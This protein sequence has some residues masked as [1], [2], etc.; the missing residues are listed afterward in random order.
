MAASV[1]IVRDRYGVPHIY[2]PTDASVVFGHA[3]AQAEDHFE[4]LEYNVLYALGRSAEIRGEQDYWDNLLA[5]AFEIPRLASEEYAR[6]AAP[7]RAIYDAYAAGVNH[8][9]ASN[10]EVK[11]KLITRFEPWHTLAMLR[12]RYWLAE[13]IWDTGLEREE[14]RIGDQTFAGGTKPAGKDETPDPPAEPA[15]G[16]NMWAVAPARTAEGH[17]LLFINPHVGFFGPYQYY[18][19]HLHSEEGLRF[20]G[21]GR[22]GFP[23][24]Y[25]GHNERLGWSH[26]DNY[27]DRGDLYAEVFDDPSDPLSYRY[28]NTRRRATEWKETVPVL[29]EGRTESRR[30]VFRKTH[31]GPL[32]GQRNGKLLAVKL[33]KAAEGGWYDQWHAMARAQSLPEFRRAL[34]RNAIPYM[35]V[36]YADGDGNILY[37]YNGIV[38]RR[39][40]KVDW[41]APVDGSDPG[42]EW[43]GYHAT[44][45]LPQVLNPPSGYLQNTNSTPFTVTTDVPLRPGSFPDYMIGPEDD[46][47]RARRSRR[48]LA[49]PEKWTFDDW[50][51]AATDTRVQVA[52]EVLPKLATAFEELRIR[53]TARAARLEPHVRLLLGWNR[54][55]TVESPAMTLFHSMMIRAGEKAGRNLRDPKDVTGAALLEALGPT[56]AAL[57]QNWKSNRV[58]WGEV[59]RLQRR[60]WNAGQEFR[61]DVPSLPVPG[62]PGW[63]GMIYVFNAWP[64]GESRRQ[65]GTSGN[66]YVSVVE[67]AP[68]VRAASVVYF[69][70]SGRPDSPHYFDQAPIYARGQ[71]K[72]AWF[73]REE[74]SANAVRRYQPGDRAVG[75]PHPE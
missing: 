31:H 37:V 5:R 47:P 51:R 12:A 50:S 30:A 17:A 64:E 42:T 3:Y 75:L 27:F 20:S 41:T 2:G 35:N 22:V 32:V 25:V 68:R 16:S 1:T 19:A 34:E 9:L 74:V 33:A 38:P 57:E 44:S 70:Q 43:K 61:D 36:I 54:V 55:S 21:V 15:Q 24:P 73:H 23:F 26:T 69:G 72:P 67:F 48:I 63:L 46:N 52:D 8:Y 53:D 58:P 28:G 71:F 4:Q 60:D 29:V 7:L 49:Q 18:E 56:V 62:G 65:Y 40:R 39:D 14:I 10:P 66:S 45:E 6:A 11:P 13:F 59:N